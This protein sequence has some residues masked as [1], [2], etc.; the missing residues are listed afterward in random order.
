MNITAVIG[1]RPE[2][3]KMCPVIHALRK[4]EGVRAALILSGQH[5]ELADGVLSEFSLSADA[6]LSLMKKGQSALDTVRGV[7]A[8]LPPLL[9]KE[10]PDLLLVHGDT[11]TAFA[12]A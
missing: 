4:R 5:K 3:I 10:R 7:L 2:A 12:A 11:S 8:G 1:T 9:A 6:D